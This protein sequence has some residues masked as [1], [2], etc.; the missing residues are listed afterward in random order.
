MSNKGVTADSDAPLR[1]IVKEI[2]T[3]HGNHFQEIDCRLEPGHLL[4][5]GKTRSFHA[6]QKLLSTI[7]HWLSSR[8]SATDYRIDIRVL[9]G[10]EQTIFETHYSIQE[11]K[12]DPVFTKSDNQCR[13]PQGN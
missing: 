9:V 1:F 8:A 4:I 5:Q 6:L 10:P 12:H 11:S 3:R 7:R 13:V 2:L